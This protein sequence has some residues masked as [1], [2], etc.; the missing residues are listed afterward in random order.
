M[1]VGWLGVE[2]G[3]GPGAIPPIPISAEPNNRDRWAML[4]AAGILGV[5][6]L[7]FG[8][9]Y[10]APLWVSTREEAAGG[11]VGQGLTQLGRSMQHHNAASCSA[12]RVWE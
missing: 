7:G 6:V 4:G 11:W 5:E 3:N 10:D 9:W 1:D 12:W 2:C 8:N